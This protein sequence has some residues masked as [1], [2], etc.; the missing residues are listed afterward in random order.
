M[1][2]LYILTLSSTQPVQS[3]TSLRLSYTRAFFS[4]LPLSSDWPVTCPRGYSDLVSVSLAS[5]NSDPLLHCLCHSFS[6]TNM[7]YPLLALGALSRLASILHCPGPPA[8]HGSVSLE[9]SSH[10]AARLISHC[11]PCHLQPLSVPFGF[12]YFYH[13]L[14][15]PKPFSQGS[16]SLWT[17]A[18]PTTAS[19]KLQ[20]ILITPPG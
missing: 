20:I 4:I 5:A 16:H 18:S 6:P 10:L 11:C 14:C 15:Y 12:A 19:Y 8:C 13:L 1:V 7:T 17:Q 9:S 2:C 3:E